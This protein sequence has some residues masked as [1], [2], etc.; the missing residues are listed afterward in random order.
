MSRVDRKEKKENH[1]QPAGDLVSLARDKEIDAI[2]LATELLI[3]P[4]LEVPKRSILV[5]GD[6][7]GCCLVLGGVHLDVVLQRAVVD[8]IYG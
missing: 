1:T 3:E 7:N 4:I 8:V 2:M 6:R 5:A